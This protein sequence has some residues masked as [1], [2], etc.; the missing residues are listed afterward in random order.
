MTMQLVCRVVP[1]AAVLA[2]GLCGPV[3]AQSRPDFTGRWEYVQPA[4]H[5]RRELAA[6]G[7]RPAPELTITHVA[8]ALTSVCAP[9]ATHPRC[10]TRDLLVSGG[11]VGANGARSSSQAFWFGSELVLVSANS[12]A[13]PGG[14]PRS[15]SYTERWSL[16]DR[17]RLR[18]SIIGRESAA[19]NTTLVY[20][21]SQGPVP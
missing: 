16:D 5:E 17:G 6:V 8:T 14:P 12:D 7:V 4:R 21:R 11:V 3:G 19:I 10:G 20:R 18:I 2:V 1:V 13:P 15:T 9:P